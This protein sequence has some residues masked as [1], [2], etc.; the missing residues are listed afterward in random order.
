MGAPPFYISQVDTV[1][2]FSAQFFKGARR[3]IKVYALIICCLFTG[4]TNILTLESLS[5]RDV[6]Q[7]LE[8]HA[9]RYGMPAI[10]YI[11]NGTQLMALSNASFNLKDL[12]DQARDSH[13][14]DIRVSNAKSHEERG[15]IE[16]RVKI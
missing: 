3:T 11:D 16:S 5:T 8:R 2:G 7:A 4:A 12:K 15:R 14:M 9:A 10:I 13:A 6:L 1:F